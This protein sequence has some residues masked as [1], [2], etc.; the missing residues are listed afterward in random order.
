M[1][2]EEVIQYQLLNNADIQ[3]GMML[4]FKI[5]MIIATMVWMLFGAIYPLLKGS[6]G[7]PTFSRLSK[8]AKLVLVLPHSN[9]GEK[10]VY[11]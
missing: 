11:Y 4:E 10:R 8:I 3:Y 9:A 1:I 6:D 2:S 7:P 5:M